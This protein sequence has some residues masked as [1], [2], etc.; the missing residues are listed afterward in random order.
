MGSE[1][2]QPEGNKSYLLKPPVKPI[3]FVG[4]DEEE[5]KARAREKAEQLAREKAEQLAREKAAQIAPAEPE[6][7]QPEE[8]EPVKQPVEYQDDLPITERSY[9][10]LGSKD[11]VNAE[12][13]KYRQ[14]YKFLIRKISKKGYDTVPLLARLKIPL[15]DSYAI[16]FWNI[17][18]NEISSTI[19]G[20][21]NEN[22]KINYYID[23]KC[24]TSLLTLIH[25]AFESVPYNN[26]LVPLIIKPDASSGK[27]KYLKYKLKY[28]NLKKLLEN[29]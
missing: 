11:D 25:K 16:M 13:F 7:I 24:S 28:L 2:S 18:K 21:K 15:E 22:G 8:I 9:F 20:V 17:E 5:R 6:E 3:P 14:P 10:R 1:Q 23:D 26:Q 12:I 27:K 29:M 19:F 4:R